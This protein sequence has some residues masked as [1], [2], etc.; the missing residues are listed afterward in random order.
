MSIKEDNRMSVS[1]NCL[2]VVNNL[3][4]FE[5]L[6]PYESCTT[7]LAESASVETSHKFFDLETG[8]G[9]IEIATYIS[10]FWESVFFQ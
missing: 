5:I 3:P 6:D 1:C 8:F 7:L 9:S 4:L 10:D 2:I